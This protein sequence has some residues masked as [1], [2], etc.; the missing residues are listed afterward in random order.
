MNNTS[1]IALLVF[2]TVISAFFSGSETG[3]MA[4]NRYRLKHMVKKG[5]ASAK[6]VYKLLSRPDKLLSVIL[7]CN[8]FANLLYSSL[9]TQLAIANFGELSFLESLLLT[10]LSSII[11]MIF[12]ESTPK[13]LA[14][15]HP[16]MIAF[17]ASR[18]LKVLLYVLYPLVWFIT[19]F[20]NNILRIFG[21]KIPKHHKHHDPLSHEELRTLVHESSENFPAQNTTM[22]IRLLDLNY[23]T[24]EDAM[25]PRNEIQAININA[26]W[27]DLQQQIVSWPFSHI[28][29]Y[30]DEINNILGFIHIRKIMD[31]LNKQQLNKDNLK[32]NLEE[33]YFIPE[34]TTLA[35][36]LL[37]FQ[38]SHRKS[39]IVVDEYGDIIGLI[40]LQ[41]ILEEV[42][43]EF[44]Q[45]DANAMQDIRPQNDNTVLI[46]GSSSIRDINR[47]LGWKLPEDGPKTLSGLIIETLETIPENPTCLIINKYK[48]EILKIQKNRIRVVRIWE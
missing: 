35:N 10:I 3:M 33:C 8:T 39:G 18:A 16:Q 38:N 40:S 46:D 7:I 4:L 23:T 45:E 43:G 9:F 29:F 15:L 31:F 22:L 14:A 6:R 1:T 44:A 17:P 34:T 11:I 24:V 20:G 47:E 26:D 2:L 12:A 36:Q 41:D 27:R 32:N 13:T 48:I 25:I 5:N 21:I 30:E 28:L 37:N 19:F 42:V